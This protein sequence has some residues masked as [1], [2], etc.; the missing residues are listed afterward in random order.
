MLDS[1]RGF[2]QVME[3]L[4]EQLAVPTEDGKLIY[5]DMLCMSWI[6]LCDQR[7]DLGHKQ[8]SK[9]IHLET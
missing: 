6:A 7:N 8:D 2:R 4:L 3:S 1:S 5:C 9:I